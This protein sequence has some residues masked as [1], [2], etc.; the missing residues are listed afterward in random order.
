MS[1][2]EFPD[3]IFSVSSLQSMAFRLCFGRLSNML[4]RRHNCYHKFLENIGVASD[5]QSKYYISILP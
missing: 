4:M 2:R 5:S 1:V 3:K